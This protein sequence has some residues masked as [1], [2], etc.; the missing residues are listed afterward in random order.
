MCRFVA[1]LGE[2]PLLLKTVLEDSAHSLI[3][4]SHSSKET[5]SGVNADGFGVGWYDREIDDN[6]AVFRSVLPAWNDDNLINICSKVKSSCFIGHIRESTVGVIGN[7]NCHPFAHEQMLFAHNGTIRHFA[8]IKRDLINCL[9]E[10]LFDQ[11]RGQTDSEHF[12]LLWLTL[13]YRA[14]GEISCESMVPAMLDSIRTLND[15]LLNR[16]LEPDYRLNTVLT[17]G[18]ELLAT[19]YI[20]SENLKPHSLY[21]ARLYSGVI[22]ASEKLTDEVSHWDEVP[23]NHALLINSDLEISLKPLDL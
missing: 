20:S 18:K 13:L 23:S 7:S 22:V 21:Y 4:Q 6:P 10:L 14:G 8:K 1:Y 3:T 2:K 19:R 17:T 9:D 16:K 12:F 5:E 11:L 15:L